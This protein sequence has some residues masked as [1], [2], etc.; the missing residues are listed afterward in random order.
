MRKDEFPQTSTNAT[1]MQWR[2][3]CFA[4]TLIAFMEKGMQ[5]NREQ[6]NG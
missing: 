2:K 4:K 5:G 6:V 1:V 3:N